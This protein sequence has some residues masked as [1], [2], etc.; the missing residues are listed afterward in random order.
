MACGDD[1]S[2]DKSDD[3]AGIVLLKV[4]VL[5][6]VASDGDEE[7]IE[8]GEEEDIEESEGGEEEEEREEEEEVE[9]EKEDEEREVGTSRLTI[10]S[11]GDKSFLT[12]FS[13]RLLC[14]NTPTTVVLL[15]LCVCVCLCTSTKTTKW[16]L[17]VSRTQVST[18]MKV[19]ISIK[20]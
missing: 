14:T 5:L 1:S 16:R 18:C 11:D 6:W 2:G 20:Q 8:V 4:R 10:L 12:M 17:E 15:Y 3:V 19:C 13:I 9:E 7:Y